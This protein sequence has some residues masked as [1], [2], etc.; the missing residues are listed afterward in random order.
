MLFLITLTNRAEPDA[1][2]AQLDA[3]RAWLATHTLSGRFIAAGPLASGTGGLI[4]A[5]GDDRAE[6]DAVLSADPFVALD[7]VDVTVAACAPA[8]RHGDF[9]ARWAPSAKALAR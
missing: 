1:V 4:V 3:H 8:L 5:H 9:P 7:L 2:H 6:L